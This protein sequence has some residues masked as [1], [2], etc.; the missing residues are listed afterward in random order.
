MR[1]WPVAHA[2]VGTASSSGAPSI[3]S[4]S[5]RHASFQ[6][7]RHVSPA[8]STISS[9]DDSSLVDWPYDASTLSRPLQ[10]THQARTLWPLSDPNEAH[11]FRFFVMNIAPTWDTTNSHNVFEKTVPQ[12]ALHNPMLLN[13]ILM[14]ASYHMNRANASSDAK[15]YMYHQ[16][17]L[18]EL[19]PYLA[20][21]GRIQDEGTLVAAVLL[22][23]FEEFHGTSDSCIA[24]GWYVE[25]M[26]IRC[27]WYTRSV[28]SVD[29]RDFSRS[30]RL[31]ARHVKLGSTSMLHGAR[32][33]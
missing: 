4:S 27:R 16:R 7:L 23:A 13:S 11:I 9:L 5:P 33:I 18:Q 3:A 12:M 30:G 14:L 22:S 26:L 29:L 24:P 31:D 32:K 1:I 6:H 2:A 19:I 17:L 20:D 21:H 15:P 25:F 28:S 10:S 8:S